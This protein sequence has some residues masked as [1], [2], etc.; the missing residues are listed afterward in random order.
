MVMS[1][2]L[3]HRI[4]I[5]APNWLGDAV[6]AL[7]AIADVCR[8]A[9]DGPVVVAARP[10]VAGL[11]RMVPGVAG[12][13]TLEWR[14]DVRHLGLMQRDARRLRAIGADV[15]V[16][17]PNSFASALLAWRARIPHRW[18][19]AGDLRGPLLTRA[20]PRPPHSLHQ[21]SYYQHLAAACGVPPGALEPDL[22]VPPAAV[23]QAR[24]LL[25]GAGW[26]A[27]PLV[28]LAPGA[29]YGTAK[30]WRLEYVAQLAADLVRRCGVACAL[31]GSAADAEAT[32]TV[33]RLVPEAV[34]PR[35]FDL[36][37]A[38]TL[39]SLAG[40]M[41]LSSACVSND[42][43]AMHLAAACGVPLAALFGPTREH[44][45]APLPRA[46][47]RTE[48]L[49]HQVDCRPCML[50]ECPIDHRCMTGLAPERVYDVVAGLL[51]RAPDREP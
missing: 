26:D 14:G 47:V 3:R 33:R 20:V 43:G 42:S 11:F 27:S 49:I 8:Y 37:G 25:A 44:E 18:G 22:R 19:Y 40:V 7:P 4:A 5:V 30:R 28:V 36:A 6:M 24:D 39:E 29:A 13:V 45:T 50:R 10:A 51:G 23:A 17:L 48:V 12:V 15:A 35:V 16:L 21:G 31:V 32:R 34:R 41:T 46:G 9:E 2:P 1:Q 38:T